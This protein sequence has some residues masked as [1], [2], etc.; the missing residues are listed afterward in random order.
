METTFPALVLFL[1]VLVRLYVLVLR[2]PRDEVTPS[3][4]YRC[5]KLKRPHQWERT[6]DGIVCI[7][8]GIVPSLN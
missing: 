7:G 5:D 3:G 6:E 4:S 2:Q 8:C 1:V